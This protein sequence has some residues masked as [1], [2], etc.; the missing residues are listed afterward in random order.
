MNIAKLKISEGKFKKIL[1]IV[2][3][4][5]IAN[6]SFISLNKN[7]YID[8]KEV[9]HSAWKIAQ[10]ERIYVDFFQ[11]H[12]PLFYYSIVPLINIIGETSDVILF[13]R[14]ISLGLFSL[15]LFVTYRIAVR[16]FGRS[17]A[18]ISLIFLCSSF[19]FIGKAAEIRPDTPQVLC[20][21]VSILFLLK[22]FESKFFRDL[23]L[24]A[25]FLSLSFLFLQKT[26]FLIAI[27][28]IML[29]IHKK[30]I[31]YKNTVL[32]FLFFS[33]VL[34]PFYLYFFLTNT[35]EEYFVFNWLINMRFPTKFSFYIFL[36][37]DLSQFMMLWVLWIVGLFRFLKTPTHR[38]IGWFSAG[39]FCSIFLVRAPY[40]QY[41]IIA[42]PFI[43]MIAAYSV[44]SIYQ[45]HKGIL[46]TILI[47]SI[48]GPTYYIT[49]DIERNKFSKQREKIDYI[50]SITD[51]EDFIYDGVVEFNL[52]RNDLDFFWFS[53][54]SDGA[55]ATYKTFSDYDYN[56]YELIDKY[57][58]KVISQTH[59]DMHRSSIVNNYIRCEE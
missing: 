31:G 8:E 37:D 40:P 23:I 25:F 56:V 24:S 5:L 7:I 38:R 1:W 14:V 58:P 34:L 49:Y 16:A 55:L 36:L 29:F 15:M 33:L 30:E 54:R 26:I 44:Y 42:M 53:L 46:I 13:L 10:G 4:I 57:K 27:I 18:V 43:A 20:G 35:L 45:K 9:V 51:E 11:H 22:Y 2:A 48:L 39:L 32:Y 28:A 52:F 21:L 50:L 47:L 41:Y 3:F 19:L 6:A 59:L 17:V 12:H